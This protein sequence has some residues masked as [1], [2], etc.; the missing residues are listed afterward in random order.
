MESTDEKKRRLREEL[1]HDRE[2]RFTPESWLHI[3]QSSEARDA[4]IIA[5]YNSYGFEP[6]T[7]DINEEIIRRGKTLLLPRTLPDND[8]EWV[9]WDGSS[10]TLKKRSKIQEPI[11]PKY[12]EEHLI[13]VVI[14]PALAIDPAGNRIG[15]GGGSYD[16]AL[17]RTRAWKVGIVGAA[18]LIH[19][20]LPTEAHDQT[21]SAAATPT[22][23]VRFNQDDLNRL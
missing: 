19:H 17:S 4:K 7:R 20:T 3:L 9:I 22:L 23:L 6:E 8:I 5:S 14:V 1:R 12:E 2:L 10:N 13:D 15:Q 21:L 16:R 11:G 18:E